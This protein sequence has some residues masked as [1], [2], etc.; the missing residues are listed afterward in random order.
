MRSQGASLPV[1]PMSVDKF[2]SLL[3]PSFLFLSTESF[4]LWEAESPVG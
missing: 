2:I 1:C 3:R 4:S